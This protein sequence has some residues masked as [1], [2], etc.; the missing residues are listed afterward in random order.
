MMNQRAAAR[1]PHACLV[2]AMLV[3]AGTTLFASAASAGG[4]RT[5][6]L[7]NA[8]RASPDG[9]GLKYAD[10]AICTI[11]K[12]APVADAARRMIQRQS[13]K[14]GPLL[15][16]MVI[17]TVGTYCVPIIDKA[18]ATVRAM[19]RS[20]NRPQKHANRSAYLNTLA[21]QTAGTIAAQIRINGRTPSSA[22]V[23][24]S[25]QALCN[26]MKSG[27]SPVSTFETYYPNAKLDFLGP[28]NG[29]AS[30]VIRRCPL[31]TAHANFLTSAILGHLLAN[32]YPVDRD[33]PIVLLLAPTET[34]Y[35][36]GTAVVTEHHSAFDFS[37]GVGKCYIWI[38][39]NG[40]WHPNGTGSYRLVKG[41]G[42]EYAVRCLDRSG[43]Y[44]AWSFT[45][46]YIA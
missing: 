33:P 15:A 8:S 12:G 27:L 13:G 4:G 32:Q 40:S 20:Q 30:M 26:V 23:L 42:F 29:I 46:S 22:Y 11:I 31:D 45:K 41:T 10:D 9:T 28:M 24:R 37:S 7:P 2:L 19:Y 39:Y 6:A 25:V 18:A 44:S 43:N 36:N 35:T 38:G 5:V 34:N 16:D 17:A 1:G 14:L 3:I 21:N